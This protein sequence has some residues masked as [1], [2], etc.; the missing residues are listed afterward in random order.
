MTI[1]VARGYF[2]EQGVDLQLIDFGAAPESMPAI[3]TG[4]LDAGSA[5]PIASFFN[6]LARGI[7]I[8]I[9]LDGSHLAP[10]ARGYPLIARLENGRPVV[11]ELADLRG[12]RMAYSARGN[13]GELAFE[14]MLAEVG[15]TEAD[16]QDTQFLGFPEILAAFGGG[17]MDVAIVPEPW[18]AIAQ[19]RGIGARVRE[20]T[21][22]I[23][24]Y[25]LSLMMYSERFAQNQVD[26][27]NRF[28]VAYVRAARDYAD[29]WENGRDRDAIFAILAEAARTEPRVLEKAGYLAVRRNGRVDGDT[30]MKWL[31]WLVERGYVPEKPDLAPMINHRF[32]DHAVQVLDRGR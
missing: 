14:R 12:K 19:D 10:G 17:S 21:D 1:G 31:D 29:A 32:A 27:A 9:A 16:L 18:G 5:A 25:Q 13:P 8:A 28:A 7:R 15:L 11:E 24:N 3:A 26:A 23:P 22:Y 2:R 30:L 6:A 4:E 20:A